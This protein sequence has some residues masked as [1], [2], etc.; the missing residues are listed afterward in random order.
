[1]HD[2][3]DN[4]LL[5]TQYSIEPN[6]IIKVLLSSQFHTD[7]PHFLNAS[8]VTGTFPEPRRFNLNIIVLNKAMQKS[9]LG[10]WSNGILLFHLRDEYLHPFSQAMSIFMFILRSHWETSEFRHDKSLPNFR[11]NLLRPRITIALDFNAH[12]TDIDSW[13]PRKC[14]MMTFILAE[15]IRHGLSNFHPA[16]HATIPLILVCTA[17]TVI[18]RKRYDRPWRKLRLIVR[19]EHKFGGSWQ[20]YL[21]Q[22]LYD[23]NVLK[24]SGQHILPS[25]LFHPLAHNN[26]WLGNG[27]E[28]RDWARTRRTLQYQESY[29]DNQSDFWISQASP[30]GRRWVDNTSKRRFGRS[31]YPR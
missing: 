28:A 2:D 15:F 19:L 23:K 24:M 14:S 26:K 25:I 27:V 5:R 9:E 8:T 1:M 31:L 13:C 30:S 22:I 20:L 21:S 10:F 29:D 16:T 4:F 7:I 17:I 11:Y 18:R 6:N 3:D 12:A